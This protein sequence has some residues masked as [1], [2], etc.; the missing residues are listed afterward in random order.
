[1]E[2]VNPRPCKRGVGNGDGGFG[3]AKCFV[4]YVEKV[5]LG[6]VYN[7]LSRE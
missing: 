5:M 4:G 6:A 2:L 7:V 1:M 3:M